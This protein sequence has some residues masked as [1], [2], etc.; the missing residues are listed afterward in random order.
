[1]CR[2]GG[3]SRARADQNHII[4]F[5]WPYGKFETNFEA[6]KTFKYQNRIRFL[7]LGFIEN[8]NLHCKLE[9]KTECNQ[10]HKHHAKELQVHM[11]FIQRV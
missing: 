2:A 7:D 8:I 10:D 3:K 9:M 1:M 4:F 6:S 11:N 5:T